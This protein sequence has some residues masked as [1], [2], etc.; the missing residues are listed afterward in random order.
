MINLYN[1]PK[2]QLKDNLDHVRLKD[3]FTPEKIAD[4]ER[5]FLNDFFSIKKDLGTIELLFN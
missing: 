2:P 5:I 4:G 1:N 3:Y